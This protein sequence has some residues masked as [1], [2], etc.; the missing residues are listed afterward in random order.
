MVKPKSLQRLSKSF[1]N[2]FTL[3]INIFCNKDKKHDFLTVSPKLDTI[4]SIREV[5]R[6]QREMESIKSI[7]TKDHIVQMIRNEILSGG[8]KAGEELTQETLAAQLGVSRMPVREALQA[9]EQ[10]GFLLRLPNRHMQV[11]K[12]ER[13]QL[14]QTFCVLAAMETAMEQLLE[15]EGKRSLTGQLAKCLDIIRESGINAARET[16]VEFHRQLAVRLGNPYISQIFGKMLEGYVIYVITSL[17]RHSQ[18]VEQ[19]LSQILDFLEAE[20]PKF[21]LQQANE[22]YFLHLAKILLQHM[23]EQDD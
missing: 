15:A 1:L 19:E 12:M 16:E 20:E 11:V 17:E 2:L 18:D 10:E 9:L 4:L 8:F 7:Q 23:E 6:E 3:S 22:H 14:H 13:K 21:Q 5:G